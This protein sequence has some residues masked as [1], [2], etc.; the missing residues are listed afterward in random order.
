LPDKQA[1]DAVSPGYTIT[2]PDIDLG[3]VYHVFGIAIV[4][5]RPWYFIDGPTVERYPYPVAA[6][7]FQ[8]VD[9]SLP[10]HWTFS[11]WG[12][13]KLGLVERLLCLGSHRLATHTPV[14]M[15]S[16]KK[17]VEDPR[18]FERLVDGDVE[19]RKAF[20]EEKVRLQPAG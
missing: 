7:F 2:G 12:P 14:A 8:I 11:Y 17:W 3:R 4:S 20:E 5:G 18:F 10:S 1:R 6:D 19:A 15:I 9:P 13:P 16:F